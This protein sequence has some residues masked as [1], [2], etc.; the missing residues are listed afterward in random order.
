MFRNINKELVKSQPFITLAMELYRYTESY[1]AD[2]NSNDDYQL[3]LSSN[4][5]LD[6]TKDL[7]IREVQ[8]VDVF[9]DYKK[10]VKSLS[11]FNCLECS[12]FTEHVRILF[13]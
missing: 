1:S 11:K 5:I 10:T 4:L 6:F 13:V 8:F 12:S 2:V 9:E 7:N 3:L